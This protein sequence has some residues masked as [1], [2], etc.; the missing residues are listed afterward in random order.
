MR[1][2]ATCAVVLGLI[3]SPTLAR[4][5]GPGDKDSANKASAANGK[6]AANRLRRQRRPMQPERRSRPAWK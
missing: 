1:A 6:S 3:V 4:A 5:G 2:L